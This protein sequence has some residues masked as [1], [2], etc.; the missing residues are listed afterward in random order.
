VEIAQ[1]VVQSKSYF[2]FVDFFLVQISM[3][4]GL[5]ADFLGAAFAFWKVSEASLISKSSNMLF[6]LK[7]SSSEPIL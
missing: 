1:K 2:R 4:F 3:K 7:V 5:L 6:K